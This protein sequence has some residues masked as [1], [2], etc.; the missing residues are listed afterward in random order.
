MINMVNKKLIF[1]VIK[2]LESFFNEEKAISFSLHSLRNQGKN[3]LL[4]IEM[5]FNYQFMHNNELIEGSQMSCLFKN[6][7]FSEN[8]MNCNTVYDVSN[9]IINALKLPDTNEETAK[10]LNFFMGAHFYKDNWKDMGEK[11]FG[12]YFQEYFTTK[13]KR[14]LESKMKNKKI[15]AKKTKI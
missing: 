4:H 11:V 3:D 5:V 8:F 12:D 7:E 1:K 2:T 15:Y 6:T 10:Y 14:D 13:L 9:N